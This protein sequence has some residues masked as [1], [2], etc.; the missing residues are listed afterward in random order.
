MQLAHIDLRLPHIGPRLLVVGLGLAAVKLDQSLP[1][2]HPLPLGDGDGH[3]PPGD[4]GAHIGAVRTLH[5][6]AGHQG[7]HHVANGHGVSCYFRT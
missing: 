4:L 2:A 1:L 3:H 7:L 6:T 5:M